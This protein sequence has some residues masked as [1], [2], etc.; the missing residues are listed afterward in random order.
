MMKPRERVLAA[1]DHREPDRVPLDFL[2]GVSSITLQAYVKLKEHL[3]LPW[4]GEK[5]DSWNGMVTIDPGILRLFGIDFRKIGLNLPAGWQSKIYPDNTFLDEWGLRRKPSPDGLYNEIVPTLKNAADQDDIESHPWP[6]PQAPG[7]VDGLEKEARELENAG[8][9]V[10]TAS[11]GG[12]IFEIAWWLRGFTNFIKDLY[13]NP[14]FAHCL[15]S[16]ITDVQ[17]AL[18][19]ILLGEVGDHVVMV[20]IEDDL[21]SQAGPLISF[22]LYRKYITPYHKKLCDFI[23]SRT[24]AKIM[25]HSCGAIEGFIPDL[26]DAGIDVLN[27]VQ[28]RAKGMD[29]KKLKEKHGDRICFHG[30]VDTQEVLPRGTS[31]DV[32]EEVRERI[33]AFAH[34]G[35]YILAPSHN[36]Q[37]DTPPENVIAMYEAAQ[38]HGQYSSFYT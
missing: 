26:I 29:S 3:G 21:G 12:G 37:I 31:Q 24:S 28:P 20:Q 7:L 10:A 34:N 27:P 4:E 13:K 9:A 17:I 22:T 8:W 5:Y 1:L 23:H 2:G 35:G 30:G 38:K 32:E 19:D 33:K 11:I 6:D 15:L 25:I 18:L 36:I 14:S 16:K